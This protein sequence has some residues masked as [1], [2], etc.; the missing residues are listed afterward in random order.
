MQKERLYNM[1][2]FF[3]VE[4]KL[5]DKNSKILSIVIPYSHANM[6]FCKCYLRE[7]K[8]YIPFFNFWLFL[9]SQRVITKKQQ[10]VSI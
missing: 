2:F 1:V 8:I 7:I 9:K 6:P 10:I 5:I 4:N 3:I